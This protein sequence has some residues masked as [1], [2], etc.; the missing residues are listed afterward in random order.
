MYLALIVMPILGSIVSGFFG[1]KVGVSGSQLITCSCVIITTFLAIIAFIEVGLNNIPVT[2]HLFRWVDAETLNISWGFNFDSLTVSMLIPVLIVSSLVHVYS[3]GYMSHDPHNQRFFS[4]LSLFT[5]MMI[6]LVTANNFLLMFVG[7]EG[8]GI[9]SY[10]L[11]SFWFTRIAAN[12]S[13]ISAFLTNRVGDCFLTIGMFAII[14]SFGNLDYYTVFSLSP[15]FNENIITIIGICLLIGAMAKSSQVGL[16]VWLPMAM[17]G[18]TPVS[19]LIHAATMVT[20]GV[21]LLMRTSPLIEYSSTVLILCLWIGAITTVFSSLIGLFQQDIK[22]VIAYSTMSQL[23]QEVDKSF[24]INLRH[25]TICVETFSCLRKDNSQITKARKY[26]SVYI[27]NILFNSFIKLIW[28]FYSLVLRIEKWKIIIISKLVG[29]SE[30]IR[31]ILVYFSHN[32]LI[33][34]THKRYGTLNWYSTVYVGDKGFNQWLAG[35]IDGDGHFI[36]TKKGSS[37][38]YIVMDIRDKDALYQILHKFG[39]SIRPM[40]NANAL[41]YNISNRKGL[42]KLIEAVNGEI[43]NPTRLLQMNKLCTKFGIQLVYPNKLT[44]NNGWLSGFI[45]SDGSVYFNKSSGQVFISATQKNKYLLDPLIN[46]YGGRVDPSSEK[47]DAFKYVIYRK[48][49]LFEMVDNY[50]SLYPLRTMKKNRINL[51]K[52]FYVAKLGLE[53]KN[54]ELLNK[55]VTFSDKWEKYKN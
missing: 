17:E 46:I 33:K 12:Q 4:Y 52:E 14:W 25:Q 55:W 11:V 34:V 32:N 8:V 9:C 38:L 48:K 36:L 42:I 6:I 3:I 20:A 41:R 30:A 44:F 40:S 23:A 24:F 50:F 31:L 37:R 7:W 27:N 18:P 43:R 35:L 26:Y 21:Y 47:G 16:H 15:Y 51:I 45:D 10:L 1:R 29:I 54:L 2:I 19:A 22:K 53:S 5:F 28:L 39:G 49:E 13:S